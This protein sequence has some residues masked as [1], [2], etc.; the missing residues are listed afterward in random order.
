MNRDLK[1]ENILICG[2]ENKIA[3]FGT[4]REIRDIINIMK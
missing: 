3:D 4:T 1:P 2:N